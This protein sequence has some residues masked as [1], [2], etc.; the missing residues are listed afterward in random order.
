M[1]PIIELQ[2]VTKNLGGNDVLDEIDLRLEGG[3]IVALLGANGAGKTTLLHLLGTLYQPSA[4]SIQLDGEPLDRSNLGLRRRLHYLP[5]IPAIG[6]MQTPLQYIVLA[7]EAYGLTGDDADRRVVEYLHMFDL[8]ALA[9]SPSKSLSRGQRYKATL[10]ALFAIDPEI[11]IMD[12]P[13]TS[14]MDP[15]GLTEMRIQIQKASERGRIVIYSTQ[16]VEVAK[17]AS[18][19]VCILSGS[20]IAGFGP[21]DALENTA[22]N[23]PG[24]RELLRQLQDVETEIE[25]DT[26]AT[27]NEPAH[28]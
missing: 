12:E 15:L 27:P 5:D 19:L 8:L 18:D 4:G 14:G 26:A 23:T 17:Q 24:L 22:D 2:G 6:P 10:V 1:S 9:D 11:W 20:K 16:L 3:K 7:L 28:D 21:I 25:V 13:F